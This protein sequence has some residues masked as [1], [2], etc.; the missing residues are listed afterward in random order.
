MDYNRE[1]DTHWTHNAD[2]SHTSFEYIRH[3]YLKYNDFNINFCPRGYDHESILD[4]INDFLTENDRNIELRD[5][6]SI[7]LISEKDKLIFKLDWATRPGT[8]QYSIPRNECLNAFGK[9]KE[10]L[11]KY[12]F[13]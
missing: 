11:L 4:F 13:L 8:L 9:L 1:I 6:T 10:D 3:I 12:K 5:D 2:D 7:Y